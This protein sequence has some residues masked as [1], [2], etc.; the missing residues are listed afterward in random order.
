MNP[1]DDTDADAGA[2]DAAIDDAAADDDDDDDVDDDGDEGKG[3]GIFAN[4]E[5]IIYITK[6]NK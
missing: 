3:R 1:V 2:I 5:D 4:Y 6:I